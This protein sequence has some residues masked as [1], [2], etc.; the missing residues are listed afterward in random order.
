MKA[1]VGVALL[2]V[3][4]LLNVIVYGPPVIA[5]PVSVVAPGV[6]DHV[7]AVAVLVKAPDNLWATPLLSYTVIAAGTVS[8][9]GVVVSPD[10]LFA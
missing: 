5:Y 8:P 4:S 10:K 3:P 2:N 6:N 7:L 9:T 1:V